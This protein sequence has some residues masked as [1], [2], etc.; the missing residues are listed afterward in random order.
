MQAPNFGG[1]F[2]TNSFE[3]FIRL[4]QDT[5]KFLRFFYFLYSFYCQ[6]KYRY[7]KMFHLIVFEHSSAKPSERWLRY[8][9][10][11]KSH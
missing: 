2:G 8:P 10:Q 1:T 7:L 3:L 6:F 4:K 9:H 5:A 11:H